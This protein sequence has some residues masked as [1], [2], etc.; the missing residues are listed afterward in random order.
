MSAGD[1]DSNQESSAGMNQKGL[2]KAYGDLTTT[3]ANKVDA[4]KP[5]GGLDSTDGRASHTAAMANYARSAKAMQFGG[6]IAK[7]T[8]QIDSQRQRHTTR[9]L[10]SRP[11]AAP[12]QQTC[13][14][15]IA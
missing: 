8:P 1:F 9:P 4:S 3:L 11:P 2:Y 5:R 12:Q 7:S 14:R 10:D 13:A 6:L 15:Y